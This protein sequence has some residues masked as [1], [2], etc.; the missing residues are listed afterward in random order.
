MTESGGGQPLCERLS[1]WSVSHARRD[2]YRTDTIRVAEE[3]DAVRVAEETD[4]MWPHAP[5]RLQLCNSAQLA[6]FAN[7]LRWLGYVVEWSWTLPQR[8]PVKGGPAASGMPAPGAQTLW[9]IEALSDVAVSFKMLRRHVNEVPIPADGRCYHGM[10]VYPII[11]ATPSLS[12]HSATHRRLRFRVLPDALAL[13]HY[14]YNPNP[15]RSFVGDEPLQNMAG[16][17]VET[18]GYDELAMDN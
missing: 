14:Y 10:S 12:P 1:T 5:L 17:F 11:L 18:Y 3:T 4:T 8:T 13:N 7:S 15:N 2:G 16:A 9:H 6:Q